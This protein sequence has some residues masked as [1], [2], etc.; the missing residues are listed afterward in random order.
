MMHM[1]PLTYMQSMSIQRE[2]DWGITK[3][4]HG[5]SIGKIISHGALP[6]GY[7]TDITGLL[8]GSVRHELPKGEIPKQANCFINRFMKVKGEFPTSE[9]KAIGWVHTTEKMW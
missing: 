3:A 2:M 6:A 7:N 8:P 1:V 5:V 9:F 4:S